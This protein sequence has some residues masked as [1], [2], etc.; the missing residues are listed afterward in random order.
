MKHKER[1][2]AANTTVTTRGLGKLTLVECTPLKFRRLERGKLSDPGAQT[3]Y[4]TGADHPPLLAA[5]R[6]SPATPHREPSEFQSKHGGCKDTTHASQK[7]RCEVMNR[8]RCKKLQG[9]ALSEEEKK[10]VK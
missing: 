1:K 9:Y 2:P 4:L 7:M 8:A 5:D 10:L 6:K 3:T